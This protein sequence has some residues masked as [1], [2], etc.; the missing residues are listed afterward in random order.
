MGPLI[1]QGPKQ[2]ARGALAKGV[3]LLHLLIRERDLSW[4]RALVTGRALDPDCT[5][6]T[7]T[8]K[9]QPPPYTRALV[10]TVGAGMDGHH[11]MGPMW[12]TSINKYPFQR[13]LFSPMQHGIHW[14]SLCSQRA[15]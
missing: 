15:A 4:R 12:G 14:R 13:A 9:E 2:R 10:A 6:E 3:L 5:G 8:D 1:P 7:P 11:K